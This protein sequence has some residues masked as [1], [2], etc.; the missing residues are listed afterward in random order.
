MEYLHIVCILENIT[1]SLVVIKCFYERD[2][3]DLIGRIKG[4]D[5]FL[6]VLENRSRIRVGY[7]RLSILLV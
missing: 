1:L 7:V 2:C 6:V 5:G 3:N 4:S